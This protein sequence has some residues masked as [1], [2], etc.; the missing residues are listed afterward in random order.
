MA[1]AG[2]R[3]L[4]TGAMGHVGINAVRAFRARGHDVVGLY[5]SHF[6]PGLAEAFGAGASFVQGDLADFAHLVDILQSRKVGGILHAAALP[7]D[8]PCRRAPLTATRVNVSATQHVL[9]AARLLR[10]H[11]VIY[12]ST[13]SVFQKWPDPGRVIAEAEPPSPSNVYAT[14]KRMGELLV[15]CYAETFGVSA[16][17]ARV[18][19]VYGPPLYTPGLEVNR[20]PIPSWLCSALLGRPV[21]EASGGDFMANFTYV[22]DVAAAL[23]ALY[24]APVLRHSLYQVSTGEHYS[25]A[26]VIRAIRAEAPGAS[27]T[28]GPGTAPYTDHTPMRGSFSIARL[29]EDTGFAPAFP[30][31]KGIAAYAEWL[32]AEIRRRE[33]RTG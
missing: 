7:Y 27:L 23:L 26:E 2:M 24:E 5:H 18:S 14:T 25:C 28:I 4:I 33:G 21:A 19:W 22:D 29:Q 9:E 12:V 17:T 32:R 11:R 13:G 16:C 31:R 30:I 10:L 3:V 15:D 6:D 1:G 20:G 8:G